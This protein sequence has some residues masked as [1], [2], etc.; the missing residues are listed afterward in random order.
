[1]SPSPRVRAISMALLATTACTSVQPVQEPAPF[2]AG[3]RPN[4]IYVLDN[5]G[6]VYTVVKPQ[7]EGDSLVGVS[8]RMDRP[9]GMPMSSVI[10]VMAPQPDQGRT[11]LM[12]VVLAAAAGGLVYFAI[13]ASGSSACVVGP[14]TGS[15]GGSQQQPSPC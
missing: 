5:R 12:A 10:R 3:K 11:T 9:V 7:V 4:T 2:I 8:P 1:M 14:G 6:R 13:H 15:G